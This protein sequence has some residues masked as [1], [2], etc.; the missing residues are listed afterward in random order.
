MKRY[1]IYIVGTY[2]A[3]LAIIIIGKLIDNNNKIKL[4]QIELENL[5][6]LQVD[7]IEIDVN[8]QD[9]VVVKTDNV[10]FD[11]DDWRISGLL[12]T[13]NL[14][15][16]KIENE[17]LSISGFSYN[18]CESRSSII[19]TLYVNIDIPV[20]ITNSPGVVVVTQ[21]HNDSETEKE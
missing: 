17:V 15:S 8:N 9:F 11:R 12:Y 5:F 1:D 4:D 7:S 14:N 21:N 6:S 20:H 19:D 16:L 10:G 13:S 2:I 18:G 3:I